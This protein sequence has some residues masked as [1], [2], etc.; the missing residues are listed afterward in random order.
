V[1]QARSFKEE[2]DLELVYNFLLE[3]LVLEE[4]AEDHE[5]AIEIIENLDD[6]LLEEL[7]MEGYEFIETILEE[8]SDEEDETP[9]IKYISPYKKLQEKKEI[10]ETYSNVEKVTPYEYWKS[11]IGYG[12]EEEYSVNEDVEDDYEEFVSNG[13]MT[14]YEYWKKRISEAVGREEMI[15]ANNARAKAAKQSRSATVTKSTATAAASSPS[16]VPSM[17]AAKPSPVKPGVTSAGPT[18][19]SGVTKASSPSVVPSSIANTPSPVK[20]SK[21]QT[22]FSGLTQATSVKR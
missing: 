19:T 2:I 10:F 9:K 7:V 1:T 4:I 21:A 3:Q 6:E 12:N 14:S 8:N 13:E 11:F 5:D 16:V 18:T 20:T 15:A 17:A 22:G